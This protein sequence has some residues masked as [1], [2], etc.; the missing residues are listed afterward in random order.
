MAVADQKYVCTGANLIAIADAIREKKETSDKFSLIDMAKAI[1]TITTDGIA[2]KTVGSGPGVGDFY[3]LDEGCTE[4]VTE[5]VLYGLL[6]KGTVYRKTLEFDPSSK[7]WADG[8]YEEISAMLSAAYA[9]DIALS[10]HW[11]LGDCRRISLSSMAAYTGNDSV[12]IPSQVAQDVDIQICNFGGRKLAD[13]SGVSSVLAIGTKDCLKADSK[14][15]GASYNQNWQGAYD[16]TQIQ[17][18]NIR[19]WLYSSFVNSLPSDFKKLLKVTK[20]TTQCRGVSGAQESTDL[21]FL[22]SLTELNSTQS[23][24]IETGPGF[25]IYKD[26]SSFNKKLG[27]NGASTNWWLRSNETFYNYNLYCAFSGGGI[28]TNAVSS[29]YGISPHFCM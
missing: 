11:S 1:Q 14:A 27:L 3:Y 18:F 20:A 4:E 17:F 7:S 6:P 13:G 23:S 22:P 16:S 5:G 2:V 12:V 21:V 8:S 29:S 24:E 28:S 25:S 15:G 10:K 9:N 19:A 26:A